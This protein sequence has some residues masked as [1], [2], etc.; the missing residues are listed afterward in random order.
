MLAR[1]FT[2]DMADPY[3]DLEW[4]ERDISIARPDGSVVFEQKGV[5]VPKSWSVN[6]ATILAQKYFRGVLGTQERERSLEQVINRVVGTIAA[7]GVADGYLV[8][9]EQ[10]Q[11]LIDELSYVLAH[12]MASFNSPDR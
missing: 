5:H 4:E 9:D 12:Q 8:D 3:A 10:A 11:I 7:R 2:K 1:H 6:A